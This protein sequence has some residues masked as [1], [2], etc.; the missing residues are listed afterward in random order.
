M[1]VSKDWTDTVITELPKER[2]KHLLQVLKEFVKIGTESIDQVGRTVLVEHEITTDNEC[3]ATSRGR[4]KTK[5]GQRIRS[6]KTVKVRRI[7]RS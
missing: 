2:E 3:E 1:Q 6:Q 7:V 5:P 4:T